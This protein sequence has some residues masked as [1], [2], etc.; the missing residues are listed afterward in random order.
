[1]SGPATF[2]AAFTG[3]RSV[4]DSGSAAATER[5][6]QRRSAGHRDRAPTSARSTDRSRSRNWTSR[7]AGST[8]RSSSPRRS[9][10]PSGAA[11][12]E[13]LNLS[14]SAGEIHAS[15]SVGLVDERALERQRRWQPQRRC[16]VAPHRSD[17]RRG[18]LDAEAGRARDDRR[19]GGDR[20]RRCDERARRQR[21]AE[22]RGREHQR[23]SRSRGHV[24]SC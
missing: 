20:H 4:G 3:T 2:K 1:M 17:P 13:Q 19:T 6:H 11:T 9:P 5:P 16:R 10:S 18:R 22:H 12:V 14:G 15:G 7:S 8:S 24:A 21:R 23:P